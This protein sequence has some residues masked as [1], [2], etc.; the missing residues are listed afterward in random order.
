MGGLFLFH[1]EEDPVITVE[2]IV[3]GDI[4]DSSTHYKVHKE[5]ATAAGITFG[6]ITVLTILGCFWYYFQKAT[7]KHISVWK[8]FMAIALI[9]HYP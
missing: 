5:A 3:G 8:N 6:E 9:P 4:N 1:E 2:N 7:P